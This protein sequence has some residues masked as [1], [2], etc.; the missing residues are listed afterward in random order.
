MLPK[1]CIGPSDA[2]VP[3]AHVDCPTPIT[4]D[5]AVL[6]WASRKLDGNNAKQRYNTVPNHKP[7]EAIQNKLKV[8]HHASRG[9]RPISPQS[10][11]SIILWFGSRRAAPEE[12]STKCER[13]T[14][15]PCSFRMARAN[16]FGFVQR[17]VRCRCPLR[18]GLSVAGLPKLAHRPL[19]VRGTF[20]RGLAHH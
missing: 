14:S 3:V 12:I 18:H 4:C 19:P 16:A 10:G 17:Q 11:T 5:K 6:R 9:I 2:A 7:D 13:S 8:A 15:V 20:A 1:D